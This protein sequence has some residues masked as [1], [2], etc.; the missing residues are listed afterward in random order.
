MGLGG[1]YLGFS[2]EGHWDGTKHDHDHEIFLYLPRGVDMI[3]RVLQLRRY[4]IFVLY[5]CKLWC[6]VRKYPYVELN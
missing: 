1:F 6:D 5:S 2:I 3:G 4:D